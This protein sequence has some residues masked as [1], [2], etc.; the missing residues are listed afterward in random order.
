LSPFLADKALSTDQLKMICQTVRDITNKQ[1]IRSFYE[2]QQSSQ[3]LIDKIGSLVWDGVAVDQDAFKE[4]LDDVSSEFFTSVRHIL[5]VAE[6]KISKPLMPFTKLPKV[7]RVKPVKALRRM[8]RTK[9]PLDT[10]A[11]HN[12]MNT[13]I[14]E[15]IKRNTNQPEQIT[16]ED[17]IEYSYEQTYTFIKNAVKRLELLETEVVDITQKEVPRPVSLTK[18][19]FYKELDDALMNRG[20]NV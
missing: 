11:L 13:L 20:L 5:G 10:P 15:T 18:Y 19:K 8:I 16:L 2:L 6:G 3:K 17:G 9:Y 1:M 7:P 4:P 14:E 12:V